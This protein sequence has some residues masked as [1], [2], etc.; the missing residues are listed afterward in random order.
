[1]LLHSCIPVYLSSG[2]KNGLFVCVWLNEYKISDVNVKERRERER[3]RE[4]RTHLQERDVWGALEAPGDYSSPLCWLELL[5]T[6]LDPNYQGLRN[7]YGL[8]NPLGHSSW[9]FQS[10]FPLSLPLSLSYLCPKEQ[11]TNNR[12]RKDVAEVRW[13][14]YSL[15]KGL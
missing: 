9:R 3:E 7:Q 11:Q 14:L 1:M 4:H 6:T 8:K 13:V 2:G 15:C 10:S 5:S 12:L